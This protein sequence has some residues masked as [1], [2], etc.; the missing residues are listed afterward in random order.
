M[1]RAHAPFPFQ[2]LL[3]V[4]ASASAG[5]CCYQIVR[6]LPLADASDLNRIILFNSVL[7]RAVVALLSGAALG[8]SGALLQQV[9]RNPIADPSTLGI[10]AGA[11]LAMAVATLFAPSLM[12]TARETIALSGGVTVMALLMFIS[13]K[14]DLEPMTVVLGGMVISLIAVALS[15]T[16]V[17]ANGE[18]MMS[19]LIWGSGS[20]AQQGWEPSQA[21]A[22]ALAVSIAASMLLLRPLG[23]IGLDEG[24]VRSLGVSLLPIRLTILGIAVWLAATVTSYVGVVG[25]IG[26]AAPALARICGVRTQRGIILVAPLI[27]AAIL[28][29]ADGIVQLLAGGSAEM[30]P[31]GAATGLLGGPVLLYLLRRLRLS[32]RPPTASIPA[33]PRRLNRPLRGLAAIALV[34]A[35]LVTLALFIGRGPEGWNFAVGSLFVDLLPFRAPRIVAAFAAGGMLAAAGTILQRMTG[36]PMA[37]PEV[38][39]VSAGAGVGLAAVLFTLSDHTMSTRFAGAAIGVLI[40][41]T[42]LLAIAGRQA[43]NTDRLLLGGLAAGALCNAIVNAVMITGDIRAFQLLAWISGST[44]EVG[45]PEALMAL[46]VAL[47]LLPLVP[48]T[49]RWLDILPL[50]AVSARSLG[51]PLRSSRAVLILIAAGLTAAASLVVGPLSFIGLIAPHMARLLGFSRAHHQLAAAILIGA[52]LMTGSDWLCRVVAFPYQ[53]PLGLFAALVGGPYFVWLLHRRA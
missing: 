26:L 13:W 47:V 22:T 40:V 41:M 43:E 44:N 42:G 30:V 53:L 18:Y 7:P 1:V 29:L 52:G 34:A 9:L 32:T 10:S 28:W 37:G 31:T 14:H 5:L 36:N 15:S 33:S 2:T 23:I 51:M 45:W 16:L 38:L 27:G 19:L 17:L 24:S 12:E 49:I 8:L 21:L 50:G 35:S 48:L 46:T 4:A 20:L 39:G 25:F 3:I 11:Q 6:L